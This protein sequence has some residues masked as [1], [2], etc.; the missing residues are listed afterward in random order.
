MH[1]KEWSIR[2][3][4]ELVFRYKWT[5]ILSFIIVFGASIIYNFCRT[6]VYRSICVFMIEMTDVGVGALEQF[7]MTRKI[8]PQGFYEAVIKSRKFR[9]QVVQEMIENDVVPI[10]EDEASLLVTNN[11]TL[12]TSKISE[13]YELEAKTN[14]PYFSY[15]LLR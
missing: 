10:T 4:I 1:D 7:S 14:D 11:L 8:R 12:S 13:L 3:Y 2:D 9:D 6:P 5:I 15:L